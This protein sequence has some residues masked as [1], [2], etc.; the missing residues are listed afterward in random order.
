MLKKLRS[1]IFL[2]AKILFPVSFFI[3]FSI[4]AYY[5]FDVSEEMPF[6]DLALSSYFYF[7]FYLSLILFRKIAK[8]PSRIIKFIQYVCLW[9]IFILVF[10][11]NS[12]VT[13]G[14]RAT[15][16]LILVLVSFFTIIFMTTYILLKI[17][18]FIFIK[19]ILKPINYIL[20][21]FFR[22]LSLATLFVLLLTVFL[23]PV[24][25]KFKKDTQVN[26]KPETGTPQ[27]VTLIQP[28]H[29]NSRFKINA[30]VKFLKVDLDND[31]KEELAAI[32]SY[33]KFPD[34][35]FYYAGFFRYNPVKKNWDEFYGEEI[36]IL[37]YSTAK[38]EIEPDKLADFTE[39][40]INMWSNEFTTLTN[41]G[42]ITGDG[43]PEIL[44]SS[45]LQ[46]KHFKNYIIISQ[47]GQS[48]YQYRIFSDENT[49][50]EIVVEDG[51]LLEKYYDET[52][53][54]LDIFEWD[55]QNL[56]FKLIESQKTK[57]PPPDPPQAVPGL[58]YISS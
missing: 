44:F 57:I 32:T 5:K 16:E 23:L 2:I 25:F 40:F 4:D 52:H 9:T 41:L 14:I 19:I 51:L 45:L 48:H 3:A 34:D 50:A 10:D 26:K 47:A 53:N 39:I 1:L 58:E 12:P 13:S 33:D 29:L 43:C 35:V 30:V 17:I 56:K 7:C 20:S 46:G 22:F 27:S 6:Y 15:M 38:E 28:W 49:M 11:L 18:P 36:N 8:T 55:K 21:N 24:Y 42:D 37:N 31:G 54:Y